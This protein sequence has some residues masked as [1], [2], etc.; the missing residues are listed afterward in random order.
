MEDIS[1]R[2][3]FAFTNR[4]AIN[5]SRPDFFCKQIFEM[6]QGVKPTLNI[7]SGAF[8]YL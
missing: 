7:S 3:N 8:N 5:Y 6:K 1:V 2:S 4:I